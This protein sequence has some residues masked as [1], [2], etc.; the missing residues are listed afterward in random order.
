MGDDGDDGDDGDE[1]A[2][3]AGGQGDKENN[4]APCPIPHSLNVMVLFLAN[5]QL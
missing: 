5:H 4:H 1:G 2:G 3:E